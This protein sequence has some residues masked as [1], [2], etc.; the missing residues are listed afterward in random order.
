MPLKIIVLVH[1]VGVGG[2]EWAMIFYSMKKIELEILVTSLISSY[3]KAD[4]GM[5]YKA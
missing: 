5:S 1:I 3:D 4:I 2:S